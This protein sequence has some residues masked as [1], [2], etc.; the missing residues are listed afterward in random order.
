MSGFFIVLEG[1]DG[2][3]TT[4]HSTLLSRKLEAQGMK[5]LRTSEPTDGPI[6]TAIRRDLDKGTPFSPLELQKRFCSDRAW[7]L[8]EVIAPA[9]R[10]GSIVISDRYIPSTFAYGEALGIRREELENMNKDFIRPSLLFLLLPPL[11]VC[12]RRLKSRE[13]LDAL[14][15]VTFQRRVYDLYAHM[16]AEDPSIIPIDTSGP[17]HASAE[18]IYRNVE[19]KMKRNL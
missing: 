9:L 16:A 14:E 12:A 2:S 13:K 6:G 4:L 1:P 15:E 3:G 18:E 11:E 7:H 19:W 10:T 5:V 8:N 17:K